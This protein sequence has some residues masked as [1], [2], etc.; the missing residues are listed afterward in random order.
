MACSLATGRCARRSA[1]EVGRAAGGALLGGE[2][3][4]VNDIRE[5]YRLP[6][7]VALKRF[8]RDKGFMVALSGEIMTMRVCRRCRRRT[9]STSTSTSTPTARSSGW[10]NARTSLFD[11]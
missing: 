2:T 4:Q 1:V 7:I 9:T 8:G 6:V 11:R 5:S 3:H 10:R